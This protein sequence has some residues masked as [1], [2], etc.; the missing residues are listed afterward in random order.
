[1]I[2]GIFPH[3]VL[4]KSLQIFVIR[5]FPC[6]EWLLTH[7]WAASKIIHSDA[8]IEWLI[9]SALVSYIVF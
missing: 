1:M 3:C 8:S 4:S 9:F 6:G 2:P 5:A 7:I